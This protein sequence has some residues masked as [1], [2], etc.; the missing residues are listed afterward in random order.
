MGLS[1]SFG[2]NFEVRYA[3]ISNVILKFPF[4]NGAMNMGL[5]QF[6]PVLFF[7]VSA[8]LTVHAN[9]LKPVPTNSMERY[10]AVENFAKA[11]FS[12]ESM[13][14]D[15]DQSR[16]QVL[17]DDAL[18]GIFNK[19][20]PHSARLSKR[21]F[22]QLTADTKGQMG[23]VG[24]IVKASKDKL[25][26]VS[27]LD[28]KPAMK[29]GIKAGD[30]IISINDIPFSKLGPDA[31]DLMKGEPGTTLKLSVRRKGSEKPLDFSIVRE[32]IRISSVTSERL[33]E[34]LIYARISSFQENTAQALQEVLSKEKKIRGVI[35]DLR[36]NPGGLLEE[37]V[38]VAD[39]F[40]ES[41]LIVSTVGR[42]RTR[43]ER[44]FAT[45][46][47]S[48]M[49]FPLIVLINEGSASASEIVAGALQDHQRSLTMGTTSF[50]KGSVQ[51]LIALADGSGI[52]LTIATYYTPNDRS[53]QAKG[54]EPDVVVSRQLVTPT[55]DGRKEANLRGHLMSEDLSD[56][57]KKGFLLKE[58]ANWPP[59]LA[60]DYQVVTAFTY[61]KGWTLF[62]PRPAEAAKASDAVQTTKGGTSENG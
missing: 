11:V 25:I 17:L 14:V 21:A 44:Q 22:E 46:Q 13:Y 9:A 49:G 12:I 26:I 16:L 6:W 61:L 24:I 19:K 47:N 50:G 4:G 38:K 48:F 30:E 7:L 23:G 42:N 60:E 43:I 36:N 55:V 28:G 56:M 53:I 62:T 40:I 51:T 1:L 33:G 3:K 58:L 32:V 10:Q 31:L 54:I 2:R 18:D 35:L 59:F 15:E 34:G 5:S 37:G 27:P 8:P 39:L 45:K 29:K 57:G 20:D 52:K 41:G